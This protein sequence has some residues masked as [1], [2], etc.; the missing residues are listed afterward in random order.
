MLWLN[1]RTWGEHLATQVLWRT[2][3]LVAICLGPTNPLNGLLSVRSMWCEGHEILWPQDVPLAKKIDMKCMQVNKIKNIVTMTR[4]LCVL[5]MSHT[6]F[7][8]NLHYVVAWLSRNSLLETHAI[9]EVYVTATGF[10]P[11][12]TDFVK[13]TLNQLANLIICLY[14]LIW[15]NAWVFV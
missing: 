2:A 4:R 14:G 7:R 10:E 3:R 1:Y 15:L 6:H 9:S 8:V 13:R 5:I 11:T 12:T